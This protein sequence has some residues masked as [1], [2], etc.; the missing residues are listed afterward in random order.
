M[1]VDV[2]SPTKASDLVALT[3]N[4]SRRYLVNW[5]VSQSFIFHACLQCI[6]KPERREDHHFARV[7]ETMPEMFTHTAPC[8]LASLSIHLFFLLLFF[9]ASFLFPPLPSSPLLSPPLLAPLPPSSDTARKSFSRLWS[10]VSW[11]CLGWSYLSQLSGRGGED[12]PTIPASFSRLS[13]V[14]H[15]WRQPPHPRPWRRLQ[16]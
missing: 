10:Q 4:T 5:K 6:Q 2:T 8:W 3:R 11:R 7:T 9:S 1:E 12:L 14:H 16:K 15:L 13:L